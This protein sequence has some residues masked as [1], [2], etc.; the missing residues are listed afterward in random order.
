MEHNDDTV[1]PEH[2]DRV[3]PSLCFCLPFGEDNILNIHTGT[4]VAWTVP[5]AL[6]V[7]KGL[8]LLLLSA[9]MKQHV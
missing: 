2:Q 9:T 5:I 7:L 3:S 1:I 8:L 4:S 6:G